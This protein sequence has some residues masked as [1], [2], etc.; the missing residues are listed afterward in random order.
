MRIFFDPASGDNEYVD[1]AMATL[2]SPV[3]NEGVVIVTPSLTGA[4]YE[5]LLAPRI[6]LT[7]ITLQL[8][9]ASCM[10]TETSEGVRAWERL[11]TAR[12]L[13]QDLIIFHAARHDPAKALAFHALAIGEDS[14]GVFAN[15]G[16]FLGGAP[17][18]T[19]I[20]LRVF[21]LGVVDAGVY[22]I[23]GVPG[24]FDYR[25][26]TRP[27]AQ[28]IATA[29]TSAD[30]FGITGNFVS[31][32]QQGTLIRVANSVANDGVYTVTTASYDSMGNVTSVFVD[33]EIP[34]IDGGGTLRILSSPRSV[35]DAT[36]SFTDTAL[37]G[38]VVWNLDR[39]Q[40]SATITQVVSD[41]YLLTTEISNGQTFGIG[42]RYVIRGGNFDFNK[43]GWPIVVT[44]PPTIND[45]VAWIP[46]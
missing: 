39:E 4:E 45:G 31:S 10:R 46:R 17:P 7:G 34:A 38:R 43:D 5:T 12:E 21:Q 16:Y 27:G 29:D 13:R 42:D 11:R 8:G 20:P 9:M 14:A 37:A 6:P 25:R 19:E 1:L 44:D 3:R 30:A 40:A 2:I 35:Y 33:E 15:N 24:D 18:T 23:E 28:A 41:A 22:G 36:A 26:I 32:Y